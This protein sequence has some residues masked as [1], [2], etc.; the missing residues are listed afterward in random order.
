MEIENSRSVPKERN[1][2]LVIA[3]E[4]SVLEERSIFD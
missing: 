1:A 4:K 2:C 3:K